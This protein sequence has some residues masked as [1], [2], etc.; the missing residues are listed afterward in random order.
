MASRK[1]PFK[2]NDW[3]ETDKAAL[4]RIEVDP[5]SMKE[6]VLSGIRDQHRQD[7]IELFG[8]MSSKEKPRD[9]KRG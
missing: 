3:I 9:K 1:V 7:L 5:I 6:T 4:K 8:E 2:Y